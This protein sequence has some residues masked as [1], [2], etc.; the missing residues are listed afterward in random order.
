MAGF[1]IA[2]CYNHNSISFQGR[3][4]YVWFMDEETEA[5]KE[6]KDWISTFAKQ[7]IKLFFFISSLLQEIPTI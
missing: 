2:F 6:L 4:N 1:P 5:Q 3:D 7:V